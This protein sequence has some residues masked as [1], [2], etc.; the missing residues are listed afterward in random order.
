MHQTVGNVLRTLLH[1]SP[2]KTV[3]NAKD[4]VDNA[5]ATAMHA[6]RCNVTTALGSP[7]GALVYAR[8]MFLNVP[9]VADWTTIAR[10]RVQLVQDNLRKDN[11]KRR[12]YD[13]KV[14]N[15]ILKKVFK[16]TRLGERIIQVHT[17]SN[18]TVKLNED[19]NKRLN[20]RR[21]IPFNI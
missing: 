6:M 21:I 2:P 12:S 20:I 16:P 19:W 18:V 4:I 9:L 10:R 13:Y 3:S 14:G 1:S 11:L 15:K 5:L 7:L 17:N 8:D